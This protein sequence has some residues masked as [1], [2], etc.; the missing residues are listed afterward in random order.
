MILV[1]S[2]TPSRLGRPSIAVERERLRRA[3][4]RVRFGRGGRNGQGVDPAIDRG[5]RISRQ[6][7]GQQCMVARVETL[8]MSP[9]MPAQKFAAKANVN[10]EL[11]LAALNGMGRD[12]LAGVGVLPALGLQPANQLIAEGIEMAMMA[13]M[14]VRDSSPPA[15]HGLRGLHVLLESPDKAFVDE[16]VRSAVQQ[17]ATGPGTR[18]VVHAH[19]QR[20]GSWHCP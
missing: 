12:A 7:I 6:D 2:F 5:R 15:D 16:A 14:L 10:A 17:S 4:W 8:P 9:M 1:G 20:S 3:G 11:V 18:R 19:R 13:L